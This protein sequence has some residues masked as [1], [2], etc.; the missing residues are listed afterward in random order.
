MMAR[1]AETAFGNAPRT[2]TACA[3]KCQVFALLASRN[4]RDSSVQMVH[5]A[6]IAMGP[7]TKCQESVDAKMGG[8]ETN[9]SKV[10][11]LLVFTTKTNILFI[12]A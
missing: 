1:T 7:V 2:V 12:S 4:G 10:R 3:T 6:L 8:R 11:V 5:A 9:A